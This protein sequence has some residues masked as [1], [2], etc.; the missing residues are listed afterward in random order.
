MKVI[1]YLAFVAS[2]AWGYPSLKDASV[3]KTAACMIENDCRCSSTTNPIS[4]TD[5]PQVSIYDQNYDYLNCNMF[6]V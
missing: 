6:L 5:A 2:F 3:C 4:A 1:L